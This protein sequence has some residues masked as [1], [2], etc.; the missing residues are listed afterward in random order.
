MST[1]RAT[2]IIAD[3]FAAAQIG[4]PDF[5]A[6]CPR[7]SLV[8][9]PQ[10]RPE[11]VRANATTR[12]EA[13]PRFKLSGRTACVLCGALSGNG[14]TY[15]CERSAAEAWRDK[16]ARDL[17]EQAQRLEHFWGPAWREIPLF[18]L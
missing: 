16:R 17:E 3:T 18:R 7:C 15:P 11:I 10:H 5:L 6:P 8:N 9:G 2:A 12:R 14:V 4:A 1:T 13:A